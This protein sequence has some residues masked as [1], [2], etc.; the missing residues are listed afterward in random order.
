MSLE[1]SRYSDRHH[2]YPFVP[3]DS[4]GEWF[5]REDVPRFGENGVSFGCDDKDL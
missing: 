3:L 2:Q 4:D 1:D 5:A